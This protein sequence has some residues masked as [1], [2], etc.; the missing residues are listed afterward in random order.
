MRSKS[1]A[2]FL[3][4]QKLRGMMRGCDT[5]DQ[6]KSVIAN[7]EDEN[8]ILA[9]ARLA[10]NEQIDMHVDALLMSIK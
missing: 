2:E 6:M 8:E 5:V 10:N 4:K 1:E 7:A 3:R 9:L